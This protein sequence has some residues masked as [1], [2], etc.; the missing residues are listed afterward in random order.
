MPAVKELV[1]VVKPGGIVAILAWSSENLL[2]GH[3]L[4]EA[5]LKATSS[6]ISPFVNG[7]KPESHFLRALGWLRD[8][9]LQE[10]AARTFVEDA[11]AP[12]GDDIRWALTELFRINGLRSIGLPPCS[13]NLLAVKAFT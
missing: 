12:L 2:P 13:G 8:A 3:P 6:G 11:Y 10:P 9:G 1:R 5:H 7:K 4:L